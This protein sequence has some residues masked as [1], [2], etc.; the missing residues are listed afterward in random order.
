MA[1]E[2]ERPL[3]QLDAVALASLT[4]RVT[5]LEQRVDS[6]FNQLDSRLDRL[7]YV[8]VEVYNANQIT[9]D[10][11]HRSLADADARLAD[12]M[13]RI[14]DSVDRRIG[15]LTQDIADR[16]ERTERRMTWSQGGIGLIVLG[17][18]VGAI[19]RIGMGIG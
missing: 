4:Q 12:A 6:G 11:T 7:S 3:R 15:T 9:A 10:Q 14:N 19:L 18:V 16:F 5:S 13:Q 8:S 1:D 2:D 17:A